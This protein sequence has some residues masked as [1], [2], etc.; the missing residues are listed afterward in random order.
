MIGRD[1]TEL[2]ESYEGGTQLPPRVDGETALRVESL[3]VGGNLTTS[4][5]T[6]STAKFSACSGTS[7]VE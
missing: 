3:S 6:S 5:S 7:V 1:A 2:A 4:R